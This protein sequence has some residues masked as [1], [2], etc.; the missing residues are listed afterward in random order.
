M[1]LLLL[2]IYLEASLFWSSR[3]EH[4]SEGAATPLHEEI[5]I[6]EMIIEFRLDYAITS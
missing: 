2:R 4:G 6:P 1:D 5:V 3:L